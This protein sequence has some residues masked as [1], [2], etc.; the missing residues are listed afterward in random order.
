LLGD[1]KGFLLGA[2]DGDILGD[3][4]GMSVTCDLLGA[5]VGLDVTGEFVGLGVT[6]FVGLAVDGFIVGCGLIGGAVDPSE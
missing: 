3:L 5:E 6:E 1:V 4:E 2:R